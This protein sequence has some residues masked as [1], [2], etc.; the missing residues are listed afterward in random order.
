ME[1]PKMAS[2]RTKKRVLESPPSSPKD[3]TSK[4]SQPTSS[5]IVE[6][7]DARQAATS[8][9]EATEMCESTQTATPAQSTISGTVSKNIKKQKTTSDVCT[10]FSTNGQGK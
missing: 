10:H 2:K 8:Q 3:I 9:S 5:E 6:I 7:S 1:E 4:E